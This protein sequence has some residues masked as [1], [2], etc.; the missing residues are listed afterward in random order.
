MPTTLG[1]F[2]GSMKDNQITH[3]YYRD[4]S[5]SLGNIIQDATNENPHHSGGQRIMLSFPYVG[6]DI[7][8]MSNIAC[9][10]SNTSLV[11]RYRDATQWSSKSRKLHLPT[12][13]AHTCSACSQETYIG[14]KEKQPQK[15]NH[16]K[17]E[18]ARIILIGRKLNY[19]C[20]MMGSQFPNLGWKLAE[21]F[22]PKGGESK[23]D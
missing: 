20:L 9:L 23:K 2:H 1:P 14:P 11:S 8:N 19:F 17:E 4:S 16:Q 10:P 18:N 5:M 3:Q 15:Q 7:Q 6:Q 22:L 12:F 13:F 21:D